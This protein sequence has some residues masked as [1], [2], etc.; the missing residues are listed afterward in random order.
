MKQVL[1]Q[2]SAIGAVLT[3]ATPLVV[4]AT[5]K[6][7]IIIVYVDDMGY[8]DLNCYG[9]TYT[10]T[11]NMDKLAEEGI[12]FN[13]YY[14]SCPISSPSRA[15]IT[16][17]M[18]PT[19][20]G[21][22][23]F[24]QDRAGNARN[25]QNDYLDD[26]APSMARALKENGYATGHF[27]KWHMGGGRD[28]N[29]APPIYNYG[30]DEYAS[31]WESPDPDPKLTA[32]NWIWGD[33]DEVKRWDRTAY[34]VDKTL[35]FLSRHPSKPCF[36]NLWP[37]DVH[38]PWVYEEDGNQ[39]RESEVNFTQVLAELDVQIGRLMKGLKDLGIDNNTMVIF[40]SDNGPAPG[41][42]G[43]RTDDLRGQKATLY[44]GG[45][46]MPFIVRWPNKIQGGQV[47]SSSVICSVD[48]FS[49]LCAITGTSLPTKYPTDG[50]DMSETLLG[51]EE[52][53]RTNPLFWEFGKNLT[54]RT[55]PHI[56]V[57]E[58]K[59]KLLVNAD[60]SN[61]EL[62][63]M[64]TDYLEKFNVASSNTDIVNRLKPMA[65]NWF[66]ASFRQFADNVIYVSIDG[67]A[68]ED[69]SSWGKATTLTNAANLARQAP[70]MQMWLKE[71]TYSL[72]SSVDFS[73]LAI[74][75]GFVGT[76]SKLSE[77]DWHSN[78]SI[79]DGGGTISP[80]RTLS[81]GSIL[82]GVIVQNGVNQLGANGNGNGG[83]MIIAN[84]TTIRNCIFRNNRTQN[85]T[86]G[87]AIH[88]NTGDVTI[89][90]SLFVNNTSSG[91]GGAVQVG[92]G[93][94]ATIINCTFSNNKSTKPG[95]AFGLGNN[96]S[97]LTVINSIAHN[98]L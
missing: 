64:E 16:T 27:G 79:V 43:K 92:G 62:Y 88:C 37:D 10:P 73:N 89:E 5:E 6:P 9:G 49:S 22:T 57:R 44:E 98:N 68:A 54:N 28:V 94:H 84:G 81:G 20:W 18:Y 71:G 59:W 17:G 2:A 58:G 78:P 32:G 77:R 48:L 52:G 15:G 85:G 76:E 50:E 30:F 19:R 55:S 90:N 97:N 24:L 38:T 74:Y 31:T 72:S 41:F 34:F 36:I 21:I 47:N 80:L 56:A 4:Q 1:K 95:A 70:G 93:T 45:I 87:A 46:R 51:E 13:Q 25:E 33:N 3:A 8:S 39:G 23:T 82:D 65:I 11:P 69:G 63:N 12:K 83:G 75:G 53:T 35:D 86:N 29:N 14:T 61:V 40:T 7:N 66:E 26:R 91:N 67:N 60:G 96:S 42:N